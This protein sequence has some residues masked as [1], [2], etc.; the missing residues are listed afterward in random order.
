MNFIT[1]N[2][3]K[4]ERLKKRILDTSTYEYVFWITL[5]QHDLLTHSTIICKQFKGME[6]L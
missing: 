5:M 1:E 2:L 3:T 6:T 4:L